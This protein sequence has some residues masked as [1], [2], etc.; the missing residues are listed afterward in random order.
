[1]VQGFQEKVTN[2]ASNI[3]IEKDKQSQVLHILFHL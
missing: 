2:A 3:Q 1:M